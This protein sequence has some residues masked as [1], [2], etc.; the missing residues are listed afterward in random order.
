MN[1]WAEYLADGH[2]DPMSRTRPAFRSHTAV[3]D[4]K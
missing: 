1:D 4:G 3:P 2:G